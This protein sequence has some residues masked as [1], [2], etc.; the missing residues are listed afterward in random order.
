MCE[1]GLVSGK[2]GGTEGD[3]EML[4]GREGWAEQPEAEL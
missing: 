2:G 1:E 3:E 4:D